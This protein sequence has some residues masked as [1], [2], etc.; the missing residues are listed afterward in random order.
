MGRFGRLGPMVKDS[1]EIEEKYGPRDP[2]DISSY[3]SFTTSS[4]IRPIDYVWGSSKENIEKSA[5]LKKY[6]A[7]DPSI[8]KKIAEYT[9]KIRGETPAY[10]G[11]GK[12]MYGLAQDKYLWE[13]QALEGPGGVRSAHQQVKKNPM[14]Y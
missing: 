9:G 4:G 8:G 7:M 3:E 6:A 11:T 13:M 10:M 12:Y 14:L 5:L 2:D 1:P